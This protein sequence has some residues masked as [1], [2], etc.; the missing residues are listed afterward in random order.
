MKISDELAKETRTVRLDGP[1][2]LLMDEKK[3]L[4]IWAVGLEGDRWMIGQVFYTCYDDALEAAEGYA[5]QIGAGFVNAAT[6]FMP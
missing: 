6:L 5:K 1:Y 2:V 3:T 4:A